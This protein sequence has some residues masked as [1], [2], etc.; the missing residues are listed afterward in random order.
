MFLALV[1]VWNAGVVSTEDALSGFN[2]PGVLAVGSLFIV[3]KGVERSRLADRAAKHVFGLRT[4]F[5]AGLL[6]LMGLAFVLSAF[7]N[8]TPVVALLI[9]VTKDWALTRGFS[10]SLLLMPLS[11]ACIFGGLVTII[12]TSTNLVVQ[13]L[14]IEAGER[15]SSIQG[16][17]FF[18]P[19]YIGVPLGIV[20][21]VYLVIAAPR[22]L[23]PSSDG[24]SGSVEGG[25]EEADRAED[26]VTEVGGDP[27]SYSRQ[28]L[29]QPS[30]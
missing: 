30:E 24:N 20:G 3:I 18:E 15:D 17:G 10:A 23:T 2:N 25:N 5:N 1:L 16:L 11:F 28:C 4:S 9:P 12:G 26:L 6:R 7:L 8:N 14:V 13:G 29:W 21:M 27:R 22:V 19:G